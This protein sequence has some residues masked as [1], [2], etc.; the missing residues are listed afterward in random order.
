MASGRSL[1]GTVEGECGIAA[2]LPSR[3]S[4]CYSDPASFGVPH[5]RMS[6]VSPKRQKVRR[7]RMSVVRLAQ[8]Q[9][10]G[11][12]LLRVSSRPLA[13]NVGVGPDRKALAQCR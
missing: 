2:T 5:R 6:V 7:K 1:V 4:D 8:R 9:F 12:L 10:A 3:T 13:R 11:V